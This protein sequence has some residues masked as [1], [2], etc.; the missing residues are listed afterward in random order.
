M[1]RIISLSNP[2][3]AQ[4]FV[5]YMRTHQVRLVI[6]FDGDQA[7]IWL[8]DESQQARV[9]QE[10]E[11][12]LREPWHAR[13]QA[14]SWQ[15]G[16]TGAGLRYQSFSYLTMLR[17]RAGPLTLGV[18]LATVVVYLLMQLYGVDRMLL[19]L[20]FPD[21]A[22]R[23]QLWR[24]FSHALMHFSLLHLLFNLMWWW[25]LGGPVERVLGTRRLCLILLLSAAVSGWV[26]YGFSGIY[27]GGLSG[28]V[29]ALMGYVWL[30]GEREPDGELHLQ[31]GLMIF[32]LL[33]LIA[34][35][36]D[37][38]GLSI[39][40][41]AHVAGLVIGLLMAWWDTYGKRR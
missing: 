41:A 20:A 16:S 13:Y 17:Q 3:L 23:L 10:L 5:D 40:N 31:R 27:F 25:Y 33:W 18:M 35:Y 36:F 11:Q 6:Q 1:I 21:A 38:L 26:Q 4:A 7:D 12:F 30:R 9:Q 24:W 15:T 28:V 37:I 39:A 32:A 29:Y 34:G 2:R 14:A 19:V 8:P 22:H